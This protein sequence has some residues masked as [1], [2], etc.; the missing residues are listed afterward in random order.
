MNLSIWMSKRLRNSIEFAENRRESIRISH[1]SDRCWSIKFTSCRFFHL[2]LRVDS[3]GSPKEM[4]M[5]KTER[6]LAHIV[7]N[8]C[9]RSHYRD[10]VIGGWFVSCSFVVSATAKMANDGKTIWCGVVQSPIHTIRARQWSIRICGW[11]ENSDELS[12]METTGTIWCFGETSNKQESLHGAPLPHGRCVC[13]SASLMVQPWKAKSKSKP[14]PIHRVAWRIWTRIW[15][16]Y[17]LSAY[18]YELCARWQAGS[19]R[20]DTRL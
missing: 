9:N 11:T 12:R 13:V 7:R 10:V 5:M 6:K 3:S 18:A 4:N 2:L 15:S 19:G 16:K 17:Y 8:V 14:V 20:I 1:R